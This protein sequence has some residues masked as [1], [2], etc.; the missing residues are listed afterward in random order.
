MLALPVF[1]LEMGW[2][3]IPRL[4]WGGRGHHRPAEQL[5]PAVCAGRAA[6]VDS[7]RA[8]LLPLGVPAL[9]RGGP[10]M[11]SLVALGTAAAFAY[12]VVATFAPACCPRAR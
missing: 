9:L 5:V 10:D 7:G 4:H 8:A 3:L 2:H 6:A 12:S 11:N 1:V